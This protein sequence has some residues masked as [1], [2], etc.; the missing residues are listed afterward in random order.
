MNI[1]NELQADGTER[2]RTHTTGAEGEDQGQTE[3]GTQGELPRLH[4]PRRPAADSGEGE[5]REGP[6]QVVT[7]ETVHA[8]RGAPSG[9]LPRV[10]VQQ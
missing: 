7:P 4:P 1:L 3:A 6:D 10:G 9:E 5:G 2:Q 8:A